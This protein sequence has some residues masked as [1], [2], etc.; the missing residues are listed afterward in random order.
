MLLLL[1]YQRELSGSGECESVMSKFNPDKVSVIIPTYN[2][3]RF[4]LDAVES[5]LSQS[6]KNIEV[7]VIDD[8]STD[9]TREILLPYADRIKYVYQE[10]RG[11]SA[12]R[13]RGIIE[14]TGEYIALLDAD[15]MWLPA[16]L[17]KQVKFFSE[18]NRVGI[19][20]CG[21][22]VVDITGETM[23]EILV[24]N[25]N[26]KLTFLT[27]LLFSNTVWGGGSSAVVRRECFNNVGLFDESL[28]SA[29]DWD[30]W[31]RVAINYDIRFVELSLSKIRVI[32]GS[33]SSS[34]N[35]ER[36][37]INELHVLDKVFNN[38]LF[39]AKGI[40][41]KIYSYRYFSA[42]REF[43]SF[44]NKGEAR[45]LVLKSI[46]SSP[47]FFFSKIENIVFGVWVLTGLNLFK[48]RKKIQCFI[49]TT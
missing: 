1:V 8:G 19:V 26:D 44:G 49:E 29:E 48:F 13:N 12:A 25:Y 34:A 16:K 35:A 10:N 4:V 3:A 47:L 45:R 2:H 36:M 31:L 37:L 23:K 27:N 40:K 14:S 30:M 18:S 6:Y 24:F 21:G 7:I 41:S 20:S 39:P 9:N 17:E 22:Y 43:F 11:L 15:D 32:Q 38:P 42:A 5:A 46:S 28:R 33:M